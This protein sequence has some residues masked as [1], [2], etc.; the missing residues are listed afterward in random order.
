MC[1]EIKH[2][3]N[4]TWA[5]TVSGEY[6]C[7]VVGHYTDRDHLTAAGVA[8]HAYQSNRPAKQLAELLG[9]R[10][11]FLAW[12]LDEFQRLGG[13]RAE[14]IAAIE[15]LGAAWRKR[16]RCVVTE[17]GFEMVEEDEATS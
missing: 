3:P 16:L 5:A 4:P 2:G 12:F 6:S 8:E 7:R 13:T 11:A 1:T 14:A 17:T 15:D 10:T 9:M